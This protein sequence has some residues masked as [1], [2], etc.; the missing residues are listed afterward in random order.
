MYEKTT[1]Q[2]QV[3]FTSEDYLQIYKT[4]QLNTTACTI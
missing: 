1:C 4:L 2:F 3:K